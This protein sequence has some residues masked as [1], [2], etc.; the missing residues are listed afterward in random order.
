M[1]NLAGGTYT[2]IQ[3]ATKPYAMTGARTIFYGKKG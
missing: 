1:S 3:T 2:M